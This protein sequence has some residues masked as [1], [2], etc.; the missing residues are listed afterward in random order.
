MSKIPCTVPD[1]AYI[2]YSKRVVITLVLC[3]LFH[4]TGKRLYQNQVNF[5]P[6]SLEASIYHKGTFYGGL[7][8]LSITANIFF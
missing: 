6:L 2:R 8:D 1:Y 7:E 5:S 3:D 4:F